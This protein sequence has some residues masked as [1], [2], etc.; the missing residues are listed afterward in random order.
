MRKNH[1]IAAILFF[2]GLLAIFIRD[3]VIYPLDNILLIICA[4]LIAIGFYF[5]FKSKK[6]FI[7]MLLGFLFSFSRLLINLPLA[8]EYP[9]IVVG[10][11]VLFLILSIIFWIKVVYEAIKKFKKK[12]PES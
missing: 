11:I 8:K 3:Y 2:A 9:F 7:F 6:I 10:I 4:F 5:I 12:S 1:F